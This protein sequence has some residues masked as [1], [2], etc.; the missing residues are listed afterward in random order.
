[1]RNVSLP[2]TA[3]TTSRVLNDRPSRTRLHDVR[4]CGPRG[5]SAAGSSRA[6]N[7]RRAR[8]GPSAW[9]R[10]RLGHHHAAEGAA[11]DPPLRAGRGE[12]RPARRRRA[13]LR[14]AVIAS[15][16]SA[17]RGRHDLGLFGVVKL[18]AGLPC[19][20][21]RSR[22]SRQIHLDRQALGGQVHA[23]VVLGVA[24][25]L[26]VEQAHLGAPIGNGPQCQVPRCSTSAPAARCG[27]PGST[28]RP[29]RRR[30]R[31]RRAPPTITA[32]TFSGIRAWVWVSWRN[33][34]SQR[35]PGPVSGTSAA[36]VADQVHVG[37]RPLEGHPVLAVPGIGVG[38]REPAERR[39]RG[40]GQTARGRRSLVLW[41]LRLRT[42]L[43]L[44]CVDRV[45][46][47]CA[48]ASRR[49]NLTPESV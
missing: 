45:T 39:P 11:A 10:Q 25:A 33:S 13:P 36:G 44:V 8:P 15:T 17:T 20:R 27:R 29:P 18:H 12:G 31:R 5:A 49:P 48:R 38:H 46:R 23:A 37:V 6:A 1:M 4:G 21:R 42:S 7:A 2:S 22:P 34:I 40:L 3:L 32:G 19:A 26:D 47:R 41:R 43:T 35:R 28:R 30:T 24:E 9:R 16:R 14:R